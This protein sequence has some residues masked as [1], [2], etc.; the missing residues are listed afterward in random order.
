MQTSNNVPAKENGGTCRVYVLSVAI[1]CLWLLAHSATRA[2]DDV[3]AAWDPAP[4]QDELRAAIAKSVPL[5]AHTASTYTEKRQCFSCHHQALPMVTLQ[6]AQEKGV[7]RFARPIGEQAAFT[8]AYFTP[9]TKR[10]LQG[11]G[12]IGGPYTAG[13]AHWGLSVGGDAEQELQETLEAYLLATQ[14][15]NGSWRIRSHRPPLEDSHFTATALAI[16]ALSPGRD[17]EQHPAAARAAESK[18]ATSK[19]QRR[20]VKQ[21]RPHRDAIEQARTWLVKAEAESNEDRT[22]RLLGLYWSDAPAGLLAAAAKELFAGQQPS[23]G[24]TQLSDTDSDTD[25]A[26]ECD[27]YATGQALWSLCETGQLAAENPAYRRGAGYLLSTQQQD[28]SWHVPTRSDPIQTYFESGFPHGES[29]FI[30]TAAT[31]W[32]TL[33][34]LQGLQRV[35]SKQ[36]AENKQILENKEAAENKEGAENKGAVENKE[37][38]ENTAL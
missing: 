34:L 16:L 24:W 1:P 17:A 21:K 27:A 2:E 6:K 14:Q 28:G 33:A 29:Q 12:M 9:R 31:C 5:L 15:E 7:G 18:A 30:S 26:A 19:D 32:A 36:A 35:E 10:L 38:V 37:A 11:N 20:Q 25:S 8:A 23:G 22:F 4:S 3:N 13:Y